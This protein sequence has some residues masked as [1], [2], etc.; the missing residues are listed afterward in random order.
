MAAPRRI[1]LLVEYDGTAF[2]GSQAQPVARTVQG[3]IEAALLR[4]TH[5]AQRL[6]F[7]GR[8]DAGVHAVGQVVTLDTQTAHAPARFIEALNHFL[9]QDVAVRTACEV[10]ADFDPRHSA[11]ARSY[12]Y[13]IE[14]GRLR[15]P[16]TARTAW[17]R[18][19]TLDVAAMAAAAGQLPR[20]SRDWSAFAGPVPA[21]RSTV[22]TLLRL[23]VRPC[24]PHRL[25]VH[26]EADAFLPHQVRRTVGALE[27]VGIGRLS[28]DAFGQLVDG[29][30]A[31]V[32]PAAPP[33][34]LT[35]MT[36]RYQQGA[37]SWE[38]V[39]RDDDEDVPPQR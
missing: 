33:Q 31:S 12:R 7:A 28:P 8:T 24:G 10:A 38:T 39:D 34:G 4:F 19:A 17:Q 2:S 26:M 23:E 37:V 14:H 11:R 5:E 13:V 15:S 18:E 22:R 30:P 25:E 21:D 35:L 20:G 29:L 1:A 36:V 27:R 3:T 9:P 32:G 6:R 16:L